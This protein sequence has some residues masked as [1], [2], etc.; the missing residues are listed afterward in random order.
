MTKDRRQVGYAVEKMSKRLEVNDQKTKVRRM[1]SLPEHD[2]T[3]LSRTVLVLNLPMERPTIESV[4]EIFSICGDV[5]LIRILRP[6]NPLPA[7]VRPFASKN[8]DLTSKVCA[9]IEFE[10]TEYALRARKLLNS[11]EDDQ[12]KVMELVAPVPSKAAKKAEERKKFAAAKQQQQQIQQQQHMQQQQQQRRY[13]QGAGNNNNQNQAAPMPRRKI[14]VFGNPKFSPIVEEQNTRAEGLNPNSHSYPQPQRK[15]SRSNLQQA[16][17]GANG[18]NSNDAA[19]I[20]AWMTRRISGGQLEFA[21]SGLTLPPNVIRQPRGPEEGKGFQRW[22]KNRMEPVAAS[23]AA[24]KA[25][26]AATI[27]EKSAASKE[28]TEKEKTN[29]SQELADSCEAA[30]SR[31]TVA[32]VILTH[33]EESCSSDDDDESNKESEKSR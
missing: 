28:I 3:A 9:L 33:S 25:S 24:A 30:I 4:A 16:G 14:G 23:A 6:G 11:E 20:S 19:G 13:S 18:S 27:V 32:P 8:P 21:R 2:E 29:E 7:D 15:N 26:E 17:S 12:L 10:R 1:D 31:L 22:V 5:A